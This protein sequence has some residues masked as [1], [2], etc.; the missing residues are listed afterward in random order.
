[1]NA[2]MRRVS[3]M[4]LVVLVVMSLAPG[5]LA[6]KKNKNMRLPVLARNDITRY[7]SSWTVVTGPAYGYWTILLPKITIENIGTTSAAVEYRRSDENTTHYKYLEPGERKSMWLSKR[8]TYYFSVAGN[9]SGKVGSVNGRVKVTGD[10]YIDR[11]G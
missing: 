8:S 2:R 9:M 11:L 3:V 5:A 6:A 10:R 7:N 4:L 1:M